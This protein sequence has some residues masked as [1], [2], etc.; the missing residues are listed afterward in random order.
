[1]S[2]THKFGKKTLNNTYTIPETFSSAISPLVSVA[3][4]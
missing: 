2:V 3:P 1:M 4:R